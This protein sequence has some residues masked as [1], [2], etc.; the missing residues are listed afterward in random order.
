[1]ICNECGVKI[2]GLTRI[3]PHC[4]Q[5]AL[6]DDELETWNFIADTTAQHRS[7]MPEDIALNDPVPIPSER[8]AQLDA[9]ER[10][11][12]YFARHSNLYQIIEDL[13]SIEQEMNRPSLG[14]WLLVGGLVAAFVY[15]PLSPFLPNFIWAYY[16]VLWG[17]VTTIGYLRAGRRYEQRKAEYALL[18]RHAKNDLHIM[19]NACTDCFLPLAWTLPQCINRMIDALQSGEFSSVGEY[20]LK[21]EPYEGRRL[22]A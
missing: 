22:A 5:R 7:N 10:M 19:Y 14:L 3:C 21:N 13:D 15:F 9:L 8:T 18:R 1:M 11:R 2:E 12:G 20:M 4:G 6:V 17:A 16:F